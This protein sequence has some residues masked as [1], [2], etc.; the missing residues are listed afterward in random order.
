MSTDQNLLENAVNAAE[1][2]I[3]ITDPTGMLTRVNPAFCRITGYSSKELLG[4]NMSILQ[5]GATSRDY[6]AD[7]WSTINRGDTWRNEIVNQR[8]DGTLYWAFQVIAP[9][10]DARNTVTHFV[11]IQHDITENRTLQAELD[12]VFTNTQDAIFLVDV[13]TEGFFRYLKLN[14]RHEQ[15]TGLHTDTVRGHTPQQV[16]LPEIA[17]HVTKKYQECV[18]ALAPIAYEETLALPGGTRVWHTH[19]TPVVRGDRVTQIVGSSRDLTDRITMEE[20]LRF[21]SEMDSL[22]GVANRRKIREELERE[23]A[24]AIRHSHA[25]SILVLDVD[26]FK[27]VN[28]NFGHDTGDAVLRAIT[29]TAEAILRPSDRLGRWGG[30]EFVIVLPET[31]KRGAVILAERVRGSI[32]ESRALPEHSITVSIGVA[33]LFDH[34]LATDTVDSLV[35]RADERLYRAKENGRNRACCDDND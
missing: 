6:Y 12:A 35:Q 5:S 9:V 2:G 16:L 30:E 29:T 22:T 26:H 10:L 31:D 24:R 20:E 3:F 32:A 28:D 18:D 15:L 4:R 13:D 1:H 21:L 11:G 19:L 25:L 27:V 34:Q 8:R 33:S 17:R 7:L 23:L 14:P